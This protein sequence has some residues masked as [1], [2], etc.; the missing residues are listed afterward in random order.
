MAV[1][2]PFKREF[3]G[4]IPPIIISVQEARD[5]FA[6]ALPEIDYAKLIAENPVWGGHILRAI[7]WVAMQEPPEEKFD[8]VPQYIIEH[9]GIRGNLEG[10]SIPTTLEIREAAAREFADDAVFGAEAL[11]MWDSSAIHEVAHDPT[12]SLDWFVRYI[13]K[14]P[15]VL[16]R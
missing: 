11:L 9:A 6:T 7:G 15:L 3:M 14:G 16:E 1:G 13:N 5:F 4:V 10:A 12:T 8:L 2:E